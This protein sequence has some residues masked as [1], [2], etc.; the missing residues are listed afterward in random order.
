LF[1]GETFRGGGKTFADNR[2]EIRLGEALSRMRAR[3]FQYA[4]G[5]ARA[6]VIVEIRA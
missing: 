2:S 4:R 1:A 5:I 6:V 3:H